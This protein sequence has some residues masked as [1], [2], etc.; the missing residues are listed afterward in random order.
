[1]S[2]V[3][4]A[5]KENGSEPL[6]FYGDIGVFFTD[7]ISTDKEGDLMRVYLKGIMFLK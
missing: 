3:D 2:E 4:K 1:M 7:H 5:R 6:Y